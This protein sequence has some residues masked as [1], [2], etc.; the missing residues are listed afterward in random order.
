LARR[1]EAQALSSADRVH[2]MRAAE[3]D[4]GWQSIN[5]FAGADLSVMNGYE[6]RFDP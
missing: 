2:D 1:L 3:L 6:S 4:D 5:R